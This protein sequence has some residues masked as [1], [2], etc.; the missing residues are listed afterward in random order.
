MG[1][2]LGAVQLP[3]DAQNQN[4]SYGSKFNINFCSSRWRSA[5]TERGSGN[6]KE[7]EEKTGLGKMAAVAWLL[8]CESAIF[9]QLPCL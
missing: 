7:E 5:E 8:Y 2:F 1:K 6:L 9:Q 3:R 4:L